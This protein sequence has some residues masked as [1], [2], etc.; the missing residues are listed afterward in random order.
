ME[1][2][3]II[4]RI[5]LAKITNATALG[6]KLSLTHM[7]FGDGGG[8]Y[9]DINES[10]TQLVGEKYRGKINQI[11][12]VDSSNIKISRVIPANI[13]GFFIREIGVFDEEGDMIAI[14]MFPETYK[15]TIE[16]G[17]TKDVMA[18]LIIAVSNTAVINVKID[19]NIQIATMKDLEELRN[20]LGEVGGN[21]IDES[22]KN[23]F[24]LIFKDNVPYFRVMEVM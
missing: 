14:G 9:P 10:M 24:K 15:P 19:P 2:K 21:I 11:E 1:F 20:E 3:T 23:E 12:V 7:A 16:E 8:S 18:N 6:E 22:N 5:G 4:T 17:A 13:G